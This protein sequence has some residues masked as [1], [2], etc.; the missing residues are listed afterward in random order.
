MKSGLIILDKPPEITSFDALRDIKR[1]LGTG[2]VG[3]TGTLDKFA[4]GLLL[5]ITGK[6]LKLSRW[7]SGCDKK[8]TAKIHFGIETDTLDPEG[9]V[10]KVAPPPER[11]DV[12]KALL[13]FTGV[14]LQEPPVYSAIHVNGKRAS[15]LAR[16]GAAPEMKKREINIYKL[17]LLS[18][19]PPFAEIFVHCSSGTYIRSLARDIAL[20]VNSRGYLQS[21]IRTDIAG[22]SLDMA[23]NKI[24]SQELRMNSEDCEIKN[25]EKEIIVL[26]IDKE[27]ISKLG[28]ARI[29]VS[30]HEAQHIF[31]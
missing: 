3:H 5:V 27:I 25:A 13:K 16:S 31:H 6:A 11:D 8:Y 10:I 29:D 15:N 18:F 26:P 9:K 23:A 22:F 1:T 14:I 30:E 12:E 24:G 7:F 17:E 2:K 19:Q 28:L 21:L 4:G 20:A